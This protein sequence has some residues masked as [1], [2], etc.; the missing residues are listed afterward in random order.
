MS[1]YDYFEDIVCINLDIST[2]RRKHAQY[3]FEKLGIPGRFFTVKKHTNGG[4]YGCFDSHIQ[5]VLEAYKKGLNNLLVFE[6]DFLPTDAYSEAKLQ[7]AIDFMKENN[8]WDIFHL[9]YSFIKDNKDGV[10]TVFSGKYCTPDVIQF[11]AFCTQALCYNK[12]A[13]KKIAETYQDYIGLVH[14]DMYISSYLDFKNYCIIP[15]LF[16]QNFYFENNN[17]ST[18]SIEYI[19]RLLFPVLAFTKLNYKMTWL[20]YCFNKYLKKY[21]HYLHMLVFSVILYKIKLSLVIPE[22]NIC[23][24]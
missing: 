17:Q 11:N 5:V 12:K 18:D 20:K 19:I 9:G 3:F 8:D 15:M 2:D 23:I 14:Y 7:A 22:K 13:I 1:L 16:D 24:R 4:M 21:W 6:D 10:T